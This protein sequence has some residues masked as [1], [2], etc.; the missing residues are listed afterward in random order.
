ME[1]KN[2]SFALNDNQSYTQMLWEELARPDGM[3]YL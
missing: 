2:V 3:I 1:K